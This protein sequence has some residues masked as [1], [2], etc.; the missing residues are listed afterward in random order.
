MRVVSEN[1]LVHN[2]NT[3]YTYICMYIHKLFLVLLFDSAIH[4]LLS[5]QF[6]RTLLSPH[7]HHHEHHFFWQEWI[8]S[9]ILTATFLRPC[10]CICSLRC[11][12]AFGLWHCLNILDVRDEIWISF[13]FCCKENTKMLK[14]EENY[15]VTRQLPFDI[16]PRIDP[17]SKFESIS[18]ISGNDDDDY[19][20][21]ADL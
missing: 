8:C 17:R 11:L 10:V 19:Y 3:D 14:T 4:C 7:H 18:R 1:Q 16:S 6:V 9:F 21:A 2:H 20:A 5:Q 15:L 13:L 12:V